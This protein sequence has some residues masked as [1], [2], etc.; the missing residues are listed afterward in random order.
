LGARKIA[1]IV[2]A[3]IKIILPELA[4]RIVIRVTK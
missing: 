1:E 4:D 3:D 2:L